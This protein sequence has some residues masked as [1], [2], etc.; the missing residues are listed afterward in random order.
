MKRTR[1]QI[2][3]P[4]RKRMSDRKKKMYISFLCDA[5]KGHLKGRNFDFKQIGMYLDAMEE[6]KAT[7]E[8]NVDKMYDEVRHWL[9]KEYKGKSY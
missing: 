6:I 8:G 9:L 1:K 2:P 4:R 3:D 7:R 5:L